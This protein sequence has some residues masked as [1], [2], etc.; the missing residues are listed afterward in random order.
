MGNWGLQRAYPELGVFGLLGFG[1]SSQSYY[2]SAL[3][4]LIF[5]YY[6]RPA[7]ELLADRA[8]ALIGERS[9]RS[10]RS[11]GLF[12]ASVHSV[13]LII[14]KAKGKRTTHASLT[15]QCWRSVRK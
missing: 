1:V 10:F 4:T 9:M 12:H 11:L 15:H 6:I 8:P 5:L 3:K 7:Y 14:K 13:H 2:Q